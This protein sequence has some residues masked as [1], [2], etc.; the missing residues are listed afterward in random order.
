[1]EVVVAVLQ[2][3]PEMVWLRQLLRHVRQE[4]VAAAAGPA[5]WLKNSVGSGSSLCAGQH[6]SLE[7]GR[8]S[9]CG[10]DLAARA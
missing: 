8:P 6:L 10:H 4:A 5:A 1:M 9:L 7:S 2:I 3:S